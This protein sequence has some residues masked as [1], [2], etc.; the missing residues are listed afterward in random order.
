MFKRLA[1]SRLEGFRFI[2]PRHLVSKLRELV[3]HKDILSNR[4]HS[5]DDLPGFRHPAA[6]GMRG[7]P[8]PALACH[9]SIR[10]G[11]L[12]CR[13]MSE[14]SGDVQIGDADEHEY[15]RG[16][17]LRRSSKQSRRLTLVPAG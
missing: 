10:H 6:K 17:V 14:S 2:Q 1:K 11:R 4:S 3:F 5:N 12:E 9:W 16:G 15:V 8:P 7:S 13:W